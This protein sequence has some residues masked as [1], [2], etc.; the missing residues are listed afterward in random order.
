MKQIKILHSYQIDQIKWDNC[1]ENAVNKK[2]YACSWYLNIVSNNWAGL[3]YG[4]YEL[5]F[6]IIFKKLF[7]F[8]RI[9]HPLFC[10]QLGPYSS[11]QNLLNNEDILLGILNFLDDKYQKFE[12]SINHFC[13]NR[14]IK[15]PAFFRPLESKKL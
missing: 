6:P 13:F 1:I 14:G 12:F 15:L 3:I 4:D 9:Y 7:F 11:D 8:K 2:L 5:I 10:Q